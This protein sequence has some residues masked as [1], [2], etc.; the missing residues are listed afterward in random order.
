MLGDENAFYIIFELIK[1]NG[2][3]FK[4]SDYIEFDR[5]HLD[6][7]DSGGYTWYQIEDDD[8]NDNKATFI[9][10]G[11][12]KKK[13]SGNKL[14]LRAADFIEYSIKEPANK[15]EPYSFLMNNNDFI[16]QALVE[17]LEKS[18]TDIQNSN[19]YSLKE[20]EK[21]E[22][23]YRLTPN[24]VLPWKYAN[25]P[26]DDGIDDIFI[27][28]IGFVQNKLCIRI[29]SSDLENHSLGDIYFVNNNNSEDIVYDEFMF[30]EEKRI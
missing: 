23:M 30:S 20:M 24:Y 3:S 10:A 22:E 6:F 25:I 1:E 26:M 5:L 15:F 28:N 12:T 18:T 8:K 27:D 4:D 21:I 17:N 14:T 2:E 13:V 9:L 11:N 19:D 29:A 7:K 16:E